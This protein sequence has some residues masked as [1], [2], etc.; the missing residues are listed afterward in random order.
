MTIERLPEN[1]KARDFR[2]Y[3]EMEWPSE[4]TLELRKV[5]RLSQ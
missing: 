3:E 4:T 5:I 1:S 2:R